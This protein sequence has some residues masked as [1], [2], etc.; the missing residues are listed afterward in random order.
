MSSRSSTASRR[1]LPQLRAALPA[2]GRCR[3]ADRPHDDDPRLGR[4]CRVRARPRRRPG[5]ARDLCVSAQPLGDPDPEPVGAAVAGRHP[6]GDVSRRVQPQQPVADGA[7]DRHRLRRRRRDRHDREHLAL[8][9]GGRSAAA[10]GV[11][12][13]R[14]D[15]LYDHLA[16]R[17]AD[18]GAD[19]AALHARC[20]RP[21][22]PRV[23]HHP[24]GHDHHLG[25]GRL[26]PG[27]DD[28]RQDPAPPASRRKCRWWRARAS[29]GSTR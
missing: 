21:P 6:G 20:G 2:G 23:R 29:N 8:H 25:R 3:G 12:G 1:C 19:P 24:R 26:D 18:R 11:E 14:A 15:R 27:A 22:V 13:L 5:R 10:G 7:D 4:R 17:V 16:D 28:V 9:R